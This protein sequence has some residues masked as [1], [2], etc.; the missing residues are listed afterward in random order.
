[1]TFGGDTFAVSDI[2]GDGRPDLVVAAGA[3]RL[4]TSAGAV[5]LG[6]G[7]GRFSPVASFRPGKSVSS[8]R[9]VDADGDGKPDL[10]LAR[11]GDVSVMRGNG[12]GGF[13]P[14]I[15]FPTNASVTE[16]MAVMDVTGDLKPDI[17]LATTVS[18]T[19]TMLVNA[20]AAG[21][22]GLWPNQ[23]RFS[24]GGTLL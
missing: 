5:L 19:I 12:I 13:A 20:S 23:T 16:G 11:S 10:V 6:D 3:G 14:G 9:I 18:N 2:N 15:L 22:V 1:D 8:V 24:A 17:A 21:G 4:G 7:T